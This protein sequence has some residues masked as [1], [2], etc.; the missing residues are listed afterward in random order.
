MSRQWQRVVGWSLCGLGCLVILIGIWAIGGYIWGVISVLG[1][2]DRSWVFWGLA[3][4]FIGLAAFGLGIRMVVTGW[5]LVK[6][7]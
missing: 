3:I 5:S 2:P 1:E 6:R 7:G 4:L